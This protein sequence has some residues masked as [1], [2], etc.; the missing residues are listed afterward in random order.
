MGEAGAF[1]GPANYYTDLSLSLRGKNIIKP[2]DSILDT[3]AKACAT[4]FIYK[5]LFNV[6]AYTD[7]DPSNPA[8]LLSFYSGKSVSASDC[9][10]EH[11]WPDSRKGEV[12]ENDPQVIRPTLN[13]ENGARGNSYYGASSPN[14]DPDSFG[15][16]KYRGIAARIIFYCAVKYEENGLTLDNANSPASTNTNQIPTMGNL[17]ELLDWNQTYKVDASEIERNETLYSKYS[18]CRNPFIDNPELAGAIWGNG[19]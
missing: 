12:T 1:N 15:A 14:W 10:R 16:P 2:L 7:Y 17:K 18:W 6:F 5:G 11:V 3:K 9:N 4:S 13:S 19:Q 8:H